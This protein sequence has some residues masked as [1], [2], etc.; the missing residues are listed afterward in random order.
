VWQRQV[1]LQNLSQATQYN[2]SVGWADVSQLEAAANQQPRLLVVPLTPAAQSVRTATGEVVKNMQQ[3]TVQTHFSHDFTR[4]VEYGVLDIPGFDVVLGMGF[5]RQCAPYQLQEDGGG[6]RS[7]RLT[8]PSTQRRILL[9]AQPLQPLLV[10]NAHRLAA[11]IK[12]E[13]PETMPLEMHWS[14]PSAE[15]Y[16]NTVTAFSVVLDSNTNQPVLRWVEDSDDHV[17][18]DLDSGWSHK[19][20]IGELEEGWPVS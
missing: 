2:G 3:A 16:A 5:L 17:G 1:L 15:D 4:R 20:E 6:R 7:V 19:L 18:S 10:P 9:E 11:A 13:Q 12:V 8:S 14:V